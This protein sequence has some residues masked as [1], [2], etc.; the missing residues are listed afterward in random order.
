MWII[1]NQ[2]KAFDR[3]CS[4]PRAGEHKRH[5]HNWV[6][7]ISKKNYL[8]FT[9]ILCI[10]Q[11]SLDYRIP[12]QKWTLNQLNMRNWAALTR[13]Y[14]TNDILIWFGASKWIATGGKRNRC[15]CNCWMVRVQTVTELRKIG[16]QMWCM[17]KGRWRDRWN[18]S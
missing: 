18:E 9:K 14:C 10:K 15:R 4:I 6:S 1:K 12:W 8:W 17:K 11:I 2:S 13:T 7:I 16:A 5:T 3:W